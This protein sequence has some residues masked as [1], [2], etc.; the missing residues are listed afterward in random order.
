MCAMATCRT[1]L[2]IERQAS[3]LFYSTLM[4]AGGVPPARRKRCK[5]MSTVKGAAAGR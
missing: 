3:H 1:A 4:I 5:Y 2:K